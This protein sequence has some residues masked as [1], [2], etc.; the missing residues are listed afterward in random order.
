MPLLQG[1]LI[2][3]TASPSTADEV[4]VR[5]V[6]GRVAG[7]S[8]ITPETHR[9]IL[10]KGEFSVNLEPGPASLVVVRAGAPQEHVPLLVTGDM[11]TIAEAVS[12]GDESWAGF[13]PSRAE[14]IKADAV[15]AVERAQAAAQESGQSQ[16]SAEGAATR[17]DEAAGR[18]IA[19]ANSAEKSV[20][21]AREHAA[22]A[23]QSAQQAT[24]SSEAAQLAQSNAQ[25]YFGR[26]QIEAYKASGHAS[27]ALGSAENA[28]QSAE[29]AA[30]EAD[31]AE[32]VTQSVSWAGD[33]L[34]VMGKTSPSLT[35]PRGATGPAASW[36]Q[37]T[38][39]PSS[40]PPNKHT[41]EVTEII[42]LPPLDDVKA[43]PNTIVTRDSNGMVWGRHIVHDSDGQITEIPQPLMNT[44]MHYEYTQ[45]MLDE[46]NTT[47]IELVRNEIR[48][49]RSQLSALQATVNTKLTGQIVA[50]MPSNPSSNVVYVVR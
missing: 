24:E 5:A 26:A 8:V 4:W 11:S 31:R 46:F 43:N 10:N 15:A 50:S 33:K 13:T 1:K 48:E 47:V 23:Q 37:V 40:F 7:R 6:A 22:R 3:V 19:S 42:D 17:A 49:L 21:E 41:H 27:R 39:K 29:T 30:A 18:S 32:N 36:S 44:G 9:V 16:A 14:V 25:A 2:D 35:G 34:T 28:A 45:M 12:L 38:G 20:A